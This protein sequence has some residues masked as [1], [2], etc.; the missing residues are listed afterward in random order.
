MQIYSLVYEDELW[1]PLAEYAHNCSWRAGKFLAGEMR[2][3]RFSDWERVFVAREDE[4]IAGYCT[5]AKVDC[6]PNVP[7]TPYIGYV[8]VGEPFRGKRLSE[9]LCISAMTYARSIGFYEVYLVSDQEN[10]YEK[11]GF[12]KLTR[13]WLLGARCRR[14]LCAVSAFTVPERLKS[15]GSVVSGDVI[16][17]A[18]V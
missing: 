1:L 2:E 3:N 8:F 16:D 15:R 4:T 11:Y 9:R 18:V 5:L 14:Y 7:Y 13:K 17:P 12:E 6:I 10:L